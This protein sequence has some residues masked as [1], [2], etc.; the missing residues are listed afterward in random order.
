MKL[1]MMTEW[2]TF[3]CKVLS[4]LKH[5]THYKYQSTQ[6]YMY[7]NKHEYPRGIDQWALICWLQYITNILFIFILH[8]HDES[9]GKL[10]YCQN[11]YSICSVSAD[12]LRYMPLLLCHKW[13][14]SCKHWISISCFPTQGHLGHPFRQHEFNLVPLNTW[15]MAESI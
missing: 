2:F 9:N 14:T 1:P 11:E 7:I 8:M 13:R 10:G 6:S 4:Q 5:V 3:S 15:N 12:F